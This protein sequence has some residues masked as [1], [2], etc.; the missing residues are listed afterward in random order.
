MV[1][2]LG[3]R[4]GF[5]SAFFAAAIRMPIA[6]ATSVTVG[7][8]DFFPGIV[9]FASPAP[10]AEDP[11]AVVIAFFTFFSGFEE[12]VCKQL[13]FFLVAGVASRVFFVAL[14]C[15]NIRQRGCGWITTMVCGAKVPVSLR[16]ICRIVLAFEEAACYCNFVRD[17]F[18][19][20]LFTTW[21]GIAKA[22]GVIGAFIASFNFSMME[23]SSELGDKTTGQGESPPEGVASTLVAAYVHLVLRLV[24]YLL[25][26]EGASNLKHRHPHTSNDG[27]TTFE[28][29]FLPFPLP[30][31]L[32]IDFQFIY[33]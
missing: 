1:G 23:L 5:V 6:L 28:G 16:K 24:E 14:V 7:F 21:G 2:A 3:F 13:P 11:L 27:V 10:P 32:L 12:G 8:S 22:D 19:S 9:L 20:T 29:Q 25:T 17:A 18:I 33:S 4:A 31:S 26:E 30:T 15:V